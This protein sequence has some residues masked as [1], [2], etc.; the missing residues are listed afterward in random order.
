MNAL[1]TP[2]S[3]RWLIV[4]DDRQIADLLAIVLRRMG[5]AE[6]E[7][8]TSSCEAHART[9][10]ELFDLVLT[11]RDMPGLDGLEF[12]R[13][14][15]LESPATKVVLVSARLEDLTDDDLHGAGVSAMLAK[16]FTVQRVQ[17]IVHSVVAASAPCAGNFAP[18]IADCA[19]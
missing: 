8:F 19:A 18:L 12:A 17:S 6:V 14:L 15:R 2:S 11:D 1:P 10:S 4:D 16:P 13:R 5:L 9:R 7:R 3:R